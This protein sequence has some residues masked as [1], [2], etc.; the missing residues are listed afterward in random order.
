MATV[1]TVSDQLSIPLFVDS[2]PPW[3][4]PFVVRYPN[5]M[6]APAEE[7][8]GVAGPGPTRSLKSAAV[9][10]KDPKLSQGPGRPLPG[11]SAT[12][13]LLGEKYTEPFCL[14][15]TSYPTWDVPAEP[16]T[17]LRSNDELIATTGPLTAGL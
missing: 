4:L 1:T 12:A 16:P 8:S 5:W 10:P 2:I 9:S 6:G 15:M 11:P 3:S 17:N 13:R 7:K 14:R